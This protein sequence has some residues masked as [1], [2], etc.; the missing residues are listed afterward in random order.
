[1]KIS[2]YYNFEFPMYLYFNAA[3][4]DHSPKIKYRGGHITGNWYVK[5]ALKGNSFAL[6]PKES[7]IVPGRRFLS[8]I[9]ENDPEFTDYFYSLCLDMIAFTNKIEEMNYE[10]VKNGKARLRDQFYDDYIKNWSP[11]IGFS[12]PLDMALDE[13]LKSHPIDIHT[14]PV[15]G[16]SFVRDEQKDLEKIASETDTQKRDEFL[17]DHAYRYSWIFSNYTGYHPVSLE[18]FA[19][20]LG[21]IKEKDISP[22]VMVPMKKPTTISEWIGFATFIRDERK[23]CNMIYNA[24]ADRYLRN[25]CKRLGLAYDD[26]V[27]LTPEEFELQKNKKIRKFDGVRYVEITTEGCRDLDKNVWNALVT[28]GEDGMEIKGSIASRGKVQGKVKIV[29]SS[30]D[31]HKMEQGDILVTSMT[32]PDFAPVFHKCGAIVT[33][34]GGITC[35]AAIISREMKIPCIIGTGNATKILKDGD[36]V[37]VDADKGVVT[38]IK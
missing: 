24:M 27:F 31:F 17:K 5:Y 37:E 14:V 16:T 6:V 29:L 1:M 25:E 36:M 21:K 12:Y 4:G 9:L 23:R 10:D 32:R 19:D 22:D 28:E 2:D 20:R 18:Y 38:I 8:W 11:V 3:H 34:E 33:N 15:F 13:Y 7:W 35:H 30:P 26:A